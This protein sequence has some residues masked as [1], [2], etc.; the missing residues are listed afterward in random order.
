M[1]DLEWVSGLVGRMSFMPGSMI[2]VRILHGDTPYVEVL[3]DVEDSRSAHRSERT[4]VCNGTHVPYFI[5]DHRDE[6]ALVEFV[7]SLTRAVV[8]HEHDEWLR[9]DGELVSDPHGVAA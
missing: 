9:L 1:T 8:L 7:K 4:R 3:V 2:L 5:L 6:R